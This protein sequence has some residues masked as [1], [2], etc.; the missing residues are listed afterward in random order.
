VLHGRLDRVS[1]PL[2]TAIPQAPHRPCSQSARHRNRPTPPT[3]YPAS[4]A[5]PKSSNERAHRQ[6]PSLSEQRYQG[7]LPPALF[8]TDLRPSSSST[9]RADLTIRLLRPLS[10]AYTLRRCRCS[11]ATAQRHRIVLQRPSRLALEI[12]QIIRPSAAGAKAKSFNGSAKAKSQLCA[13]TAT[14]SPSKHNHDTAA[15]YVTHNNLQLQ[16]CYCHLPC[17]ARRRNLA[18]SLALPPFTTPLPQH[19]HRN[20]QPQP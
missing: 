16:S 6:S 10:V 3:T 4:R 19:H 11:F 13:T 12:F 20:P 18:A 14:T 9:L 5:R 2:L 7:D 17:P 8:P 15:S 1:S